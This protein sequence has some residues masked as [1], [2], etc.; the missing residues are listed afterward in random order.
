MQIILYESM[1]TR[2]KNRK[3][4]CIVIILTM[5]MLAGCSVSTAPIKQS[6]KASAY[7]SQTVVINTLKHDNRPEEEKQEIITVTPDPKQK[8][9]S[10]EDEHETAPT[11][12]EKE[13]VA[14]TFSADDM[15]ITLDGVRLNCGMDFLPYID[16]MI[17]EPD[18]AEGMACLDGGY[19]TNYYYDDLYSIYTLAG[20]NRQV[21]YDIYVTG[22]GYSNYCGVTIGTTTRAEIKEIYG[23]PT[24]VNPTSDRYEISEEEYLCFEYED[25]VVFAIDICKMDVK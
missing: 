8:T 1:V 6:V 7:K 2:V 20:V 25:D 15:F 13:H 18:I 17:T 12:V 22:T 16:K 23:E 19:D 21:I 9:E 11:P 14:G 5:I 3:I 24:K 4:L 10:A